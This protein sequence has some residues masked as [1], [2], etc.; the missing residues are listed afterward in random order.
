M[1]LS[2]MIPPASAH[3]DRKTSAFTKTK[4]FTRK[5]FRQST[6]LSGKQNSQVS[7]MEYLCEGFLQRLQNLSPNLEG[8]HQ[9]AIMNC[10]GESGLA[11]V[12]KNTLI[13]FHVM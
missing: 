10:P 6:S 5:S 8:I 4:Q 2:T 7:E 12:V 11:G 3:V 9:Q 1:A 13:Q